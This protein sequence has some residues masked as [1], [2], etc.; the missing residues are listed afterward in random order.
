M[1]HC[2][3]F[4]RAATGGMFIHYDRTANHQLSNQEIDSSRTH[5]NYN[6][7]AQD[8]PLAQST[9]LKKRLGEVITNGRKTQNVMCDW[10]ITLPAE[11]K[12]DDEGLFFQGT[13]DY[14]AD[15]Y[16]RE[17]V[18]SA[19]VH[20][21]ETTPH[22]HFAFVPV[23]QTEKGEKLNAKAIINRNTLRAFHRE[24]AEIMNE[25]LGYECGVINGIVAENGK[26]KT[27]TELKKENSINLKAVDRC[28][29]SI[30]SISEELDN[31]PLPKPMTVVKHSLIGSKQVKK[32]SLDEWNTT[33]NLVKA[34]KEENKA[35]SQSIEKVREA[36]KHEHEILVEFT[37]T[38]LAKQNQ[39]LKK[40]LT[41]TREKLSLYQ[42]F[43]KTFNLQNLFDYFHDMIERIKNLTGVK[44]L[45][46]EANLNETAKDVYVYSRE[47][48]QEKISDMKQEIEDREDKIMNFRELLHE[49]NWTDDEIRQIEERHLNEEHQKSYELGM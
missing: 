15:K 3:K 34:L 18:I 23:E 29:A 19:Y 48:I 46:A 17:N 40:E 31:I 26:N 37:R 5:L 43:I 21:D 6:L 28:I 20:Q 12:K 27:I 36:Y 35:L 22:M 38:P 13:Y 4:V 25:K 14:L 30:Q 45:V 33:Q 8:Q 2:S 11:V 42:K 47:Q 24:Y 16:G 39:E 41:E 9:F 7:A 32:L 1:A 49:N 10:V 44:K